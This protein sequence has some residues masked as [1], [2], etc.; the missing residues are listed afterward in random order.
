MTAS[1]L[2]YMMTIEYLYDNKEGVRLTEVARTMGVSKVSVYHAAERLTKYEYL[3]RDEKSRLVPTEIGVRV[4]KEHVA[5]AEFM[6][7]AL[8]RHCGAPED[9]ALDDALNTICALSII[10]RNSIIKY[11]KDR[12]AIE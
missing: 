10:S 4:M 11:L 7:G 8:M 1:E 6:K 5:C 2:K 12:K 3:E 9:V